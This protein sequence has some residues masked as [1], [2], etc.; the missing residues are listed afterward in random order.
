[1]NVEEILEN[2][3]IALGFK[4]KN[5]FAKSMNNER[6]D[7]IDYAIK[8]NKIPKRL[9]MLIVCNHPVREEY[10][11]TGKEPIL[12]IDHRAGECLRCKEKDK[13]IQHLENEVVNLNKQ[14]KLMEENRELKQLNETA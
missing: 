8:N 12:K 10:L 6:V 1:M 9:A 11:R 3:W 4:T 14:I 13:T 2:V 5:A 7:T